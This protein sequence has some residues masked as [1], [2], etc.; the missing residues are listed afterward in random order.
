[1]ITTT[2][3]HPQLQHEHRTIM[4]DVFQIRKLKAQN[5]ATTAWLSLEATRSRNR[6][7]NA[8]CDVKRLR[9]IVFTAT[10][11]LQP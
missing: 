4:S 3:R 5:V 8:G 1:M 7:G 10:N 2:T 9:I 6:A 11:S